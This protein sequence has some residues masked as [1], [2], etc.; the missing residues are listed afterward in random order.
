[1]C[2]RVPSSFWP[3]ERGSP[4]C[5]R[6]FSPPTHLLSPPALFFFHTPRFWVLLNTHR[7]QKRE[8]FLLLLLFFA[9]E[10]NG[11]TDEPRESNRSNEYELYLWLG[12]L[13]AFLL[14]FSP[15]E[16]LCHFPFFLFLSLGSGECF[17][18]ALL[19]SGLEAPY[20][21]VGPSCCSDV[22][23]SG[24]VGIPITPLCCAML[25]LFTS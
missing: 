2:S 19:S 16:F 21:V 24:F 20:A 12:R 17:S 8:V 13:V 4:F 1:M 7:Q 25:Y 14:L 23:G 3:P 10:A 15:K 9:G 22:D 11:R 5:R 18:F 6:L